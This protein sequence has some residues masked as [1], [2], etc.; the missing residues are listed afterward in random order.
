MSILRALFL[1][2]ALTGALPLFAQTYRDPTDAEVDAAAR[3]FRQPTDAEVE[4]IAQRYRS[5]ANSDAPTTMRKRRTP[6]AA[7]KNPTPQALSGFDVAAQKA[8]ELPDIEALA[9]RFDD[10]AK[11]L[12]AGFNMPALYLF[13]S[14]SM[15]EASL[16]I[17]VDDAVK[18]GAVIVMR[19]FLQDG[20]MEAT[21]AWVKGLIGERQVAWQ[22]DPRLYTQFG[23]E[24]VPTTLLLDAGGCLG[25]DCPM[26][27]FVRVAGDV[28]LAYALENIEQGAPRFAA[29]AARYRAKLE[30]QR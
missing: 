10:V 17:A 1:A 22:I 15:P 6:T 18:A 7:G 16:K 8:S 4:K 26:P 30:G 2:L 14:S 5:S 29:L 12:V 13:L 23:I 11:P 25:P 24:M 3:V 9:K 20:S 28:R 19:G 27:P 21:L